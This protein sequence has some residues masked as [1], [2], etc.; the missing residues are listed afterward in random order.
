M[1]ARC[2]RSAGMKFVTETGVVETDGLIDVTRREAGPIQTFRAGWR[3][4]YR[5]PIPSD[6]RPRGQRSRQPGARRR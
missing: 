3:R 2:T 6:C 1:A 5:G 4:A